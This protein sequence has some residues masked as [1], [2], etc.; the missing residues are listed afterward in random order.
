MKIRFSSGT[1]CPL[2][3]TVLADGIN[4]AVFSRNATAVYLE[5]FHDATDASPWSSVQLDPERNRT[6]DVWHIF[7]HRL[8]H[9]QLY[10]FRVDGPYAPLDGHRFNVNKLLSD[11]YAR[12]VSGRYD[13]THDAP[14][15][16]QRRAA[17]AD[18][19]FSTLD[20]AA[21]TVKSVAIASSPIDWEDDRKPRRALRDTVI[22]ECH[23]KGFTAHPSS[24]VSSPGTYLGII[25]KIR[26]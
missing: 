5:L 7:A 10:G 14:Y 8:R 23:L 6:G 2:G 1:P 13:L 26:S 18:L 4:F 12:A 3:A 19:S 9:G 11:P 22:Y 15:G 20:S 16:Y 17:L 25:D 24:A 21:H